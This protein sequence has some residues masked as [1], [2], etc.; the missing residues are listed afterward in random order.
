MA[1]RIPRKVAAR[2]AYYYLLGVHD[3]YRSSMPGRWQTVD[4]HL[5]SFYSIVGRKAI[6]GGLINK[7]NEMLIREGA[8]FTIAKT[9]GF[10]KFKMARH[11]YG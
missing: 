10:G 11:T 8:G 3:Q 7:I 5:P 4:L 9:K 1:K 6:R 2:R